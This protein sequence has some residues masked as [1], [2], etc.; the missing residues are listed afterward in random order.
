MAEEK[1]MEGLGGWL[2]PVGIGIAISPLRIITMVAPIYSELF[3]TGSWEIL[4]TPGSEAYN[5]LWA[6]ILIGEIL[7]NAAFVLTWLY[8]AFLFF[9]KKAAFP[10]WY[11]SILLCTLAFILMDAFSIKAVMPSEPVFDPDTIKTLSQTLISIIIWVPYMLVSK[12]VKA[13]FIK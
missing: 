7:I 4:T 11:I 13:T 5:S 3:S 2:I 1:S 10:K 8:I 9:S 12:R 6:P